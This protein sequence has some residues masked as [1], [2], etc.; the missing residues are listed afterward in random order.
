VEALG[1]TASRASLPPWT[2]DV[3]WAGTRVTVGLS[4]AMRGPMLVT[5]D[6][7]RAT[8]AGRR[9]APSRRHRRTHRRLRNRRQSDLEQH[10]T[11][12]ND[13]TEACQHAQ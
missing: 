7:G 2:T 13:S 10:R 6:R 4:R 11:I 9:N 3:P 1:V 12:V 5:V 8:M